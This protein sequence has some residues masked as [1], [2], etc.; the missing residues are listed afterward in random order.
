M[1]GS[2]ARAAW[3]GALIAAI[4]T[5]PGLGNGTLWDNSETA[6]GEVAREILLTG[7]AVVMHLNGHPW[8]VQP[9]LYFWLAAL[10]AKL[11]GVG[12]V[13][14]RLPA[15][16]ATI[17]M[18]AAVAAGVARVAGF[19]AGLL[20]SLVL[21]TSLMQ[22]VIG[23]LAIMDAL[24]DGAVLVATLAWFRAFAD[25][26]DDAWAR[27]RAWLIGSVALA[28]GTLAKGPVAPA[29]VVL[30]VGLWL[31]WEHRTGAR[32]VIP[33][34]ATIAV[35][36][37]GFLA[38]VLP[39]FVAEALRVGPSAIGE[40]ILHYT[41]GRYTGVI[42]NQRGPWWYYVPV[43]ILGFFPW[44]AFAPVAFAR[45]IREPHADALTRLALTWTIV[46]FVFFSLA[47]TKLPNYIALIVP[48]LAILVGRWLA[49]VVDGGD[50]RGAI[51][52]AIA[53]PVTIGCF[54]FA[55][56]VFVRQAHVPD[57][58][59]EL[60]HALVALTLVLL[61]GALAAVVAFS[62]PRAR[63]FAPWAVGASATAL[64][65]FVAFVG[66]PAAEAFK[67]IPDFARS[68][69]AQR[70]P[71]AIVA[72]RSVSGGNSLVFY[73][74]PGVVSL[75]DPLPDFLALACGA[76]QLFVI[77]RPGDVDALAHAARARGRSAT[78]TKRAQH[79]ALVRIDGPRC[80]A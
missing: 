37:L 12:S 14:M 53:L 19:R 75:D 58:Y 28:L 52:S 21:T 66:E 26:P 67:P 78:I 48:A 56:V 65:F 63:R 49:R 38:I 34:L 27:A 39:W 60:I 7:D 17:G 5:L 61:T 76:P 72:V 31:V 35:A 1:R 69:E 29:V 41:I 59:G 73:S 33:T 24:L 71:G 50:I 74:Q 42:E 13:A 9:P 6:Y 22:A 16:L 10:A 18:G 70:V 23:R 46:P 68:I 2:A 57:A 4:V 64:V 54:A 20:A 77:T 47:Q 11:F 62:L 43:V 15:A 55:L 36:A 25:G 32:I 30:V 51:G 45:A 79:A 8:F 44:T 80:R 40:L 3:L